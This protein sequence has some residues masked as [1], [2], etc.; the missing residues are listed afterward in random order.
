MDT[1]KLI[2]PKKGCQ[3]ILTHHVRIRQRLVNERQIMLVDK[4]E[5]LPIG[6]WKPRSARLILLRGV[7]R[8]GGPGGPEPPPRKLTD[9]LTLFKPRGAYYAPHTNASPL[10]RFKKLSTPLLLWVRWK[11]SRGFIRSICLQLF[12]N[13]HLMAYP[14]AICKTVT[15]SECQPVSIGCF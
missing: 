8:G 13:F 6:H 10:P 9:Q 4:L 15:F 5:Q 2:L 7:D 11:L 12:T 1:K 14:I 3:P